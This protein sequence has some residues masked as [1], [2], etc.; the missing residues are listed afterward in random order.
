MNVREEFSVI[1]CVSRFKNSEKRLNHEIHERTLN[2]F[3]VASCVS[4]LIPTKITRH[5]RRFKKYFFKKMTLFAVCWDVIN[6]AH[7]NSILPASPPTG[8][9]N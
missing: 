3:R 7:R 8:K 1:S 2:I 4:W 5:D 9:F 6:E